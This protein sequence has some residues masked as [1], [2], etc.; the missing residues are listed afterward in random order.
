MSLGDVHIIMFYGC[1]ENVSLTRTIKFI[2][3]TFLKI[4]SAYQQEAKTIKFIQCLMNF[5]ETSQGHPNYV[6]K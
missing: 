2:T 6:L 1:P 4:V 5:G 3:I